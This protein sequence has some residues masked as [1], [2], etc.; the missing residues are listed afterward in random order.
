MRKLLVLSV[1]LAVFA[2]SQAAYGMGRVIVYKGT[3]KASK[4]V[5][6]VN[7]TN[8]FLSTTVQGYWVIN[9]IEG[10][11]ANGALISSSAV[12]YNPKTKYLKV[13]PASVSAIELTP[14]DPCRIVLFSYYQ[15]D[16]EGNFSFYATGKGKLTKY[17]D[18]PADA[19]DY[20]VPS[21]KGTGLVTSFDFFDTAD[22]YSGTVNVSMTMDS[23]WTRYVNANTGSYSGVDD[24]MNEI[25]ANLIV[26][27]GWW[28]WPNLSP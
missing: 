24:V 16:A 21:F 19:K 14:Y 12:I 23:R 18:D 6:D 13:I 7:D 8:N 25:V 15:E 3:I 28:Q 4:S 1:L 10:G 11:G 26:K 27:G 17:S 2:C 22:T 9:V 5:F 20:V